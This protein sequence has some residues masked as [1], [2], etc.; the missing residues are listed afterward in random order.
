MD[1]TTTYLGMT[2]NTP[3]V[4][5][6]SPLSQELDN[7]K[8]MEDAG[9]SAVVL[10]SLF[11]EQIRRE[12]IELEHHLTYAA[13]SFA[14][15]LTYFPEPDNFYTGPEQ[16][17]DNIRVA[18]E[19]VDVP[20]IAS[21][22]GS[23][24]GGWIEFARQIETAGAD[25]LELNVYRIPTD[26]FTPGDVIE[27]ETVDVVKTVRD[28]VSIPIAV[29]ISPFYSNT[30][31]MAKKLAEA[32]T[33]GLVMFNR[34]YQPDIDLETISVQP[35]VLLSTPPELR[36]P[37]RWI[38]ILH[39]RLSLDFAATTGIHT[40]E[41]AIKMLM[42]GANVTM[43]ASALFKNGI[44]HLRSVE[45]GVR[46]WLEENEYESIQ[47]LRGSLSQKNSANPEAFER[48]QYTHAVTSIPDDY[49]RS[50]KF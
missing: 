47:Q 31:H 30:A 12:Q 7:I 11:E 18:K 1:L 41:D 16:Y 27:E 34:F 4:V 37:L 26:I 38:A 8:R 13:E 14:E 42:V 22:N 45:A 29:K 33:N 36:L 19:Q 21:L 20:I 28:T 39:G 48:A 49:K 32:G 24:R 25:A 15:A 46:Y 50:Y 43:M 23:T 2:L 6:A 44:D 35:N 10:Y 40:A 5:S 9:A 17:L 3:L